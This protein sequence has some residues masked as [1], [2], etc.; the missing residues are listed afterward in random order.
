MWASLRSDLSRFEIFVALEGAKAV[1]GIGVWAF[2]GIINEFGAVRSLYGAKK[3]L[4]AGD[5]LKWE[6][7]KWGNA[8]GLRCYD[9]EGVSPDPQ[10][11]KDAAIRQF[12]EKW[13]GMLKRY[14]IFT[15]R[16]S[17]RA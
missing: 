13:G 10:S 11:E 17:R 2:N 7:I 1:G 5:I 12:K 15:K 16:Y 3:N 4:Y 9:L 8:D 14:G 6:I